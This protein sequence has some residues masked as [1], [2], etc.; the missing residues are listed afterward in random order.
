MV[1]TFVPR[2]PFGLVLLVRLR[3]AHLFHKFVVD[4]PVVFAAEEFWDNDDVV[5]LQRLCSVQEQRV[6]LRPRVSMQYRSARR[7]CDARVYATS[8]PV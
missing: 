6:P 4:G 2:K 8:A 7:E 3:L 1:Q 5:V